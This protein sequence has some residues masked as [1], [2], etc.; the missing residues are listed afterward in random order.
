MQVHAQQFHDLAAE[1]GSP[2][3]VYDTTR[4]QAQAR[5]LRALSLPFGLTVRYAVKANPHPTIIGLF[6]EQGLHFDAS[7]SYEAAQLLGL[8]IAGEHVSLSSQQ[9]AHNL[10]ELLQA[11]V[12][13]VATSLHQLELF[14]AVDG[15]P[16][17][18][19]L[20]VNPGLGL[21]HSNRLTTGGPGASF[22]LWHE[23]LPNA[24]AFAKQHGIVVDR[25]H[26]HVGTGGDPS[27]WGDIM[28]AALAI[29]AQVPSVTTLDIGGG[30]KIAYTAGD[31]AADMPQIAT[32]FSQKLTAFARETG[33]QLHLEIEPGRWLV[34]QSGYLVAEVV[35]IVDTGASG[36]TFL[37]TNTGMND[38]LRPAM[39]GAQHNIQVL[40]ESKEQ[41]D[42]I[43]VGHC[44]ET[45]DILTPAPHDPEGLQP[46]T[47]NKASIGDLLV[48]SDVGAYCSAMSTKGYNA[49]PSAQEVFV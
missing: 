46:R 20:R 33:R 40:N 14:T 11:G 39:Y 26:V 23:H 8:G 31:T 37:R 5:Q 41:A 13:Y 47:L 28:D 27:K 45:S 6:A 9:P 35:D 16:R 7:S 10:P 21:G 12:R 22:G 48:I 38:F 44:C 32:V 30:F 17:T 25:L 15:H 4:L 3:H 49:F 34:A 2:L 29:A 19:G 42:Y 18:V 1:H 24:L 36:F 43:V